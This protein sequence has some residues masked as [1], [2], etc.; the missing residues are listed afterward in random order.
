MLFTVVYFITYILVAQIH[1]TIANNKPMEV[2]NSENGGQ[3]MSQQE[4]LKEIILDWWK[5]NNVSKPLQCNH[6]ISSVYKNTY[7]RKM[8]SPE[9]KSFPCEVNTASPYYN[10]KGSI[11][12]GY[13]VGKGRLL[14]LSNQDWLKLPSERRKYIKEKHVCFSTT[15]PVNNQHVKEIIGTFKNGYMH[16][17]TRITFKDDSFNIGT[18]KNGKA[19]GYQ[20]NFNQHGSL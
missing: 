19:H 7:L 12:N 15:F 1:M 16:G 17:S 18:Y 5:S 4:K 9:I 6:K 11:E 2:H 3:N 13:L 10:F 8:Q 14:F 20:R